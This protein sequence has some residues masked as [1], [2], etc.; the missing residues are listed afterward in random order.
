MSTA[1]NIVKFYINVTREADHKRL[2]ESYSADVTSLYPL[3]MDDSFDVI[4]S[5]PEDELSRFMKDHP[6][7]MTAAS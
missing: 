6:H 2:V 4:G 5:M 3:S 7:A 1:S